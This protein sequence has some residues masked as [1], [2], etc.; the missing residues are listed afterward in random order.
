MANPL[1]IGIVGASLEGP[2]L[3]VRALTA[4]TLRCIFHRFPEA[5][6]FLLDYNRQ[7]ASYTLHVEGRE[8]SVPLVNMRFSKRFFQSN[9]IAV[10]ILL[11]LVLRVSRSR[12]LRGKLLAKNACLRQIDEADFF[13]SLA[14]GDS[15]SDIYGPQRLIYVALP[16]VLVLLA[17]KALILMPQTI[18][19]FRSWFAKKTARFILKRTTRVFS[20]DREGVMQAEALMGWPANSGR[21]MFCYDVGFVLEP[22]KPAN[23]EVEGLFE[24]NQQG[25][26]LVGMNVSGLLY[27]G[28][29]T[30]KNMFGLQAE[31]PQLVEVLVEYFVVRTGARV[32]LI[33]HVVGGDEDT[34]S[35]STVCEKLFGKLREK[36]PG[37]LGIVR[38]GYDQSEIKHVIG[39]CDFFVGSRMHACIAAISQSVPAISLAYSGKFLGLMETVG[40][41]ALVMDLTRL[42][43]EQVLARTGE[44]FENRLMVR[45]ALERRMPQVRCEVLNLF[46]EIKGC[47]DV[48]SMESR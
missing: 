3:G 35:D 45:R 20:R 25:G 41:G 47:A 13:V 23:V 17:R 1:K 27:M 31:Y 22:S 15:F 39:Q 29:Y 40:A 9:N 2:N 43:L 30:G 7:P 33:P 19:P 26:C 10:L 28:G 48:E 24:P 32:L 18:G 36:Y 5:E 4:G 16:Q 21:V 46:A 38:G 11:M 34:E 6:V 14:G 42:N 37:S 44:I 12:T 8:V